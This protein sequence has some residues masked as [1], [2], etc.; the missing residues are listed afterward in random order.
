[1][2]GPAASRPVL[3]KLTTWVALALLASSLAMLIFTAV[4]FVRHSSALS[5]W[6][7]AL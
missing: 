5:F 4:S 1:M 2:T 7:Q 3:R 6:P